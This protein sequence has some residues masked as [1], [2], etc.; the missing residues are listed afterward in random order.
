MLC[1]LIIHSLTSGWGCLP[2]CPSASQNSWR[3]TADPSLHLAFQVL[4]GT[5]VPGSPRQADPREDSSARPRWVQA[6]WE[7]SWAP[8]R[9]LGTGLR[10][11][12]RPCSNL[13]SAVNRV[14]RE[15]GSEAVAVTELGPR[16]LFTRPHRRSPAVNLSSGSNPA[17]RGGS[18]WKA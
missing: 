1:C 6:S 14:R 3:G 10:L 16:G 4:K 2:V 8:G 5:P 13:I 17:G 15:L 9:A 12:L 18:V 7:G 11:M